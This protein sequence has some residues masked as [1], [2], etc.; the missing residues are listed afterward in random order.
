M[1]VGATPSIKMVL[2]VI[3]AFILVIF[4]GIDLKTIAPGSA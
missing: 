3:G 4:N 1:Y 2:S